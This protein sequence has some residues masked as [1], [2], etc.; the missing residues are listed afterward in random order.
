ML[1]GLRFHDWVEGDLAPTLYEWG[2]GRGNHVLRMRLSE[3]WGKLQFYIWLLG[4]GL[5]LEGWG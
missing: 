4:L 2:I 3:M 1:E 5:C